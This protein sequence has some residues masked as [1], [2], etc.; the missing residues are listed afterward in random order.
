M[1][2]FRYTI[3]LL[4]VFVLFGCLEITFA[5]TRPIDDASIDRGN[6]EEFFTIPALTYKITLHLNNMIVTL[7]N[8]VMK[9]SKPIF[10]R[11]GINNT[12]K[13]L[14]IYKGVVISDPTITYEVHLSKSIDN[15]IRSLDTDLAG[16]VYSN[17]DRILCKIVL[18]FYYHDPNNV[19]EWFYN[20]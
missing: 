19:P 5:Q 1:K 2:Y 15:F 4:V 6:G 14:F 9:L 10:D 16:I 13:K 18:Y 12:G 17:G 11:M 7:P 3:I 20:N 8:L